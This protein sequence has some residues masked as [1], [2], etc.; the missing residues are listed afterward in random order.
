MTEDTL[1]ATDL[2]NLIAQ[3]TVSPE[4]ALDAALERT[5]T[6]NPAINAVV[7]LFETEARRAIAEGLPDGPLRGLPFLLKDL[8][9]ESR[10]YPA[11]GGSRL[12]QG[13]RYPADGAIVARLKA[14][15]A[16]IFGRTSTPEGGIGIATE[17]AVYGGPTRNPWNLDHTPGGSSGGAAAAVAASIVPA[18]HGSDGGGSVRVPASCTG[19]VGFK[20]T[21]ARLPDGPYSGEGWAGMAIDG[22]LTRS[23]R[24]TA[25]LLDLTAGPD[26]GAPYHAPPM[27]CSYHAALARRPARL[28]IALCDTTLTGGA[29]SP[30]CR[31][32]VGAAGDLLETLGHTV[33]PAAPLQ[34]STDAMMRAW[35]DIVACGLA[36]SVRQKCASRGRPLQDGELEPV[37]MGALAHARGIDGPRYLEAVETVHDYG[38]EMAGFFEDWDILLTSTLA[39][40]PAKI[41]RFDHSNPDF[42]DYRLGPTGIYPYSPFAA[43]FNATGQPA[44]SL[45]LAV[46]DGGLPIGI[47]LAARFGDDALLMSLAAQIE[48]AAPWAHRHPSQERRTT[49]PR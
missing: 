5:R 39:E 3:G 29:I 19:L 48:E 18:A 42:L 12:F 6:R 17:A 16:V 41:G 22:F 33:E 27:A 28:K 10:E 13:A 32:A 11:S 40:P 49:I 43:A 37:A 4:A 38:R 46:S 2:I 47:H 36:L 26:P 21:R 7:S 44:V 23:L 20:P 1:D 30:E 15:G 34:A 35:V 9:A 25:L 14:A 45:P 24:D 31:D 8:G